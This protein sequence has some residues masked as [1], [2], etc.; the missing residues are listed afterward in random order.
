MITT[1]N[2]QILNVKKEERKDFV[3]KRAFDT[4]AGLDLFIARDMTVKPG[5]K[6]MVGTNVAVEIPSGYAGFVVPRSSAGKV[7]IRL[8]NTIGIIDCAYRGEIKLLIR[9]SGDK[10]FTAKTGDRLCQLII[11]PVALVAPVVVERLSESP[12]G[13][14]G[15]GHTGV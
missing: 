10:D 13:E 7:D 12:R 4:D 9:N 2:V 14:G 8:A 1:L 6:S 15:F 5:A 3:P 11:V